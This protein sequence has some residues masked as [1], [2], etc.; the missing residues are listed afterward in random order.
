[1]KYKNIIFDFGNVLGTFDPNY[2]LKQFCNVEEDYTLLYEALYENWQSLDEGSIEYENAIRIA[3]SRI[4]ERLHPQAI[5][6]FKDWYL[7][8]PALSQ[9][10]DFVRELKEKNV[11][12]YLLSNASS[13]FAEHALEVCPILEEFDGILFSGPVHLAKPDP[14]IYKLLFERFGL[15]P[16]ECFFID[17]NVENI[18]AAKALGMDGI[19][20]TGDVEA[21]KQMI[22]F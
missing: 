3:L 22:E 20:F 6:F 19:V 8:L 7:H 4:P 10:C 14:E 17:D 9:T 12:V 13:Y 2:I 15:N 18:R 11:L 5:T 16:E 1:M 21:V